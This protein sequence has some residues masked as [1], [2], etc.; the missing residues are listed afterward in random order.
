MAK[1]NLYTPITCSFCGKSDKLVDRMIAGPD[2]YICNECVELC[3]EVLNEKRPK[4]KTSKSKGAARKLMSPF[5]LNRRL[6]EY[7]IGQ[8]RAKKALSVAVYNHYKR[9]FGEKIKDEELDEVELSKSNIKIGR[10]SCRE[11]V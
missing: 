6:D 3:Y 10:A 2:A 7:V 8:D 5:E 1:D 4:T 11:R 9:V